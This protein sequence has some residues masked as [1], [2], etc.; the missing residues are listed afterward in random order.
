MK[1]LCSAI[2]A[3]LLTS[4]SASAKINSSDLSGWLPPLPVETKAHSQSRSAHLRSWLPR[5]ETGMSAAQVIVLL[6][7]PDW[8]ITPKGKVRWSVDPR[9]GI[10]RYTSKAA[11]SIRVTDFHFDS[12]SRVKRIV[13]NGV[14]VSKGRRMLLPDPLP[15][16]VFWRK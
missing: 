2:A 15:H 3:L 4:L 13:E 1:A 11:G 9:S 5:V 14:I 6:G 7:N 8:G 16:G 10:L 12:N